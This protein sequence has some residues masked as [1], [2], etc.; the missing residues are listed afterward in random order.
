MPVTDDLVLRAAA[1]SAG[2]GSTS[3]MPGHGLTIRDSSGKSLRSGK[4]SKSVGRYMLRRSGW[5]AKPMPN[6]SWVS[7]SCQLAPA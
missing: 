1:S 6:I 2:I 7:R 5:P 4:P 3:T